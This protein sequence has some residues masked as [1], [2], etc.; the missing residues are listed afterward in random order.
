M[1]YFLSSFGYISPL[2]AK[3]RLSLSPTLCS[4]PS[5]SIHVLKSTFCHGVKHWGRAVV[6]HS[7]MHSHPQSS[8]LPAGVSY[9]DRKQMRQVDKMMLTAAPGSTPVQVIVG[10]HNIVFHQ[11]RIKCWWNSLAWYM[12]IHI[13][14]DRVTST[15]WFFNGFWEPFGVILAVISC[16]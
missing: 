4:H 11:H 8:L 15:F 3:T 9:R 2:L 7:A 1:S 16:S 10:C 14:G 5:S 12:L 6:S 13:W